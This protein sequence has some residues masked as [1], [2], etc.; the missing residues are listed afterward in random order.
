M[1]LVVAQK[2]TVSRGQT[3]KVHVSVY[4]PAGISFPSDGAG[5]KA[6]LYK[7][8]TSGWTIYSKSS[9]MALNWDDEE[10]QENFSL[11]ITV[12]EDEPVGETLS[13]RVRLYLDNNSVYAGSGITVTMTAVEVNGEKTDLSV[14]SMCSSATIFSTGEQGIPYW[15]ESFN[16][17][18]VDAAISGVFIASAGTEVSLPTWAIAAIVFVIVL[19][20]VIAVVA[21]KRG[22]APSYEPLE[23][24]HD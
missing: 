16:F 17:Y 4:K 22:T 12:A 14:G 23:M 15:H 1:S 3:L 24:P 11:T 20:I 19:I 9:Y 13:L 21:K 7:P 6:F 10:R 18:A 8:A 2:V 5:L